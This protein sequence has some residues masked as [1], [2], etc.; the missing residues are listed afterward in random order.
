MFCPKCAT[1]LV[2]AANFCHRCGFCV[3]GDEFVA[4]HEIG[5]PSP[6][7]ADAAA[8]DDVTSNGANADDQLARTRPANGDSSAREGSTES[9]IWEGRYSPK[10]MAASFAVLLL[11]TLGGFVGI[12]VAAL[13]DTRWLLVSLLLVLPVFWILQL[14]R[15]AKR[16]LSA[17]YRLT[18]RRLFIER[19]I[20]HRHK[21]QLELSRV[22]DVRIRQNVLHRF[23]DVGSIEVHPSDR[24]LRRVVMEGIQNADK[25][26]E[27][28]RSLARE[29]RPQPMPAVA[30]VKA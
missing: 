7:S 19:G 13:R 30:S 15:L 18:D 11:G 2:D 14:G 23:L 28:I 6:D 27:T 17:H 24:R 22:E 9:D 29:R 5:E 20:V 12:A 26:A 1:Q 8:T 16:F 4:T 25:V 10:A 21:D 3:A